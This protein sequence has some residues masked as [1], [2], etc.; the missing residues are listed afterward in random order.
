MAE[1]SKTPGF[2]DF[3]GFR[4]DP[5]TVGIEIGTDWLKIVQ[6]DRAKNGDNAYQVCLLKLSEIKEDLA[7]AIENQFRLLKLNK[8]RVVACI[9]RHFVTVRTLDLPAT[10]PNEIDSMINLQVGKQTPY[11]K[12]DIFFAYKTIE[13]SVAG[14]TRVMLAIVARNIVNERLD[15]FLKAG[16][17]VTNVT[18]SSEG[19]CNW[20]LQAYPENKGLKNT[21]AAI[22]IDV[23]SNFS[24]FIVVRQDSMVFTRNILIGSNHFVEGFWDWSVK[25]EDEIKR[26]LERYQVEEKN[27]EIVKAYLSGSGSNIEGLAALIEKSLKIPVES[28]DQFKKMTFAEMGQDPREDHFKTVSMTQAFGVAEAGAKPFIDLL[29]SER[30]IQDAMSS[31]ARQ[32]MV[33]GVLIGAIVSVFSFFCL[34]TVY[35]KKAYLEKINQKIEE[36]TVEAEEINEMRSVVDLVEQRLDARGSALDCIREIYRIT[37]GEITLTSID[38]EERR[39]VILKGYGFT[40]SDVFKYVKVLEESDKYETV[41]TAY[42]RIKNENGKKFAEFEINCA[43]QG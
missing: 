10:D 5:G 42:T 15:A 25:F 43:F 27:I 12:E 35:N 9:P 17:T 39:A 40:M 34:A 14:Y 29:P 8:Q 18:I 28:T 16:L 22:V 24:D 33:L 6:K 26:S 38:V 23:E 36:I 41:K 30:R 3:Q 2:F 1:N 13:T 32:L 31:K 37:P 7:A 21:Q 20:F 19:V 11:A 4:F